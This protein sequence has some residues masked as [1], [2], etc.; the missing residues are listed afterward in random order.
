VRKQV[1]GGDTWQTAILPPRHT[2]F[3]ADLAL[4]RITKAST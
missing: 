2:V 3:S 4:D 1:M